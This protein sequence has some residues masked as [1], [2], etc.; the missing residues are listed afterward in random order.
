MYRQREMERL[1]FPCASCGKPTELIDLS[2]LLFFCDTV[3]SKEPVIRSTREIRRRPRITCPLSG[4]QKCHIFGLNA[5]KVIFN[6]YGMMCQRIDEETLK[7][8]IIA[9]NESD[10]I[11]CCS[12]E[13]NVR[14]KKTEE[15]FLDVFIYKTKVYNELSEES[16][17]MYRLLKTVF[18]KMQERIGTEHSSVIDTILQDFE[19]L[20][21]QEEV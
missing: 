18:G 15:D 6:H 4:D 1:S 11:Y 10:N 16:K 7:A 2:S 14:D 21:S 5:A 8:L 19:A 13:Q 12:A 17:E 20:A 9:I 3:C